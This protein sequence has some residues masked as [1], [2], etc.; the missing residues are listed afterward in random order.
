MKK[1]IMVEKRSNEPSSMV[2]EYPGQALV[3]IVLQNFVYLQPLSR[4]HYLLLNQT[5]TVTK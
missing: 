2:L 1:C 5:V 3:H 4:L